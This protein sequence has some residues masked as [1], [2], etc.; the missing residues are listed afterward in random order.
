MAKA[1][2]ATWG[3]KRE[4]QGRPSKFGEETIRIRIPKSAEREVEQLLKKYEKK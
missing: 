4:G 2:K 3:G 1:K